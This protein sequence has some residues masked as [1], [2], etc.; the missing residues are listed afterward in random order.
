M[1]VAWKSILDFTLPNSE[2]HGADRGD[3]RDEVARANA[4]VSLR[5]GSPRE[6]AG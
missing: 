5:A 6:L 1:R 2:P 3:L 4:R